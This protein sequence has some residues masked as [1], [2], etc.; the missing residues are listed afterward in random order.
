MRLRWF[1]ALSVIVNCIACSPTGPYMW[2]SELP[3]PSAGAAKI[4]RPGDRLQ[5]VVHGQETMSG[6]F[7]VRPGGEVLLPVAGQFR[8]AGLTVAALS[9]EVTTRLQGVLQKPYVTI[10]IAARRT[11]AV[12]VLGE[13]KSPGRYELADGE[14]LLE[15]LARSGGLTPFADNSSIFVIRRHDKA[16]R[17][18]FR[19]SDLVAGLP[20]SVAFELVQGDVVVAE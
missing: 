18:R 1:L 16:R 12:S 2:A 6:E 20:S 17:I 13:V 5:V 14:G 8:A 11:L 7:E 15:L 4:V 19:Y 3:A 10:V 9:E